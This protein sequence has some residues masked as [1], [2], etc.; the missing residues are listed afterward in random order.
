M[1]VV[2]LTSARLASGCGL[3]LEL[4]HLSLIL[5]RSVVSDDLLVGKC[6][7]TKNESMPTDRFK[8]CVRSVSE[9]FLFLL[10]GV[11]FLV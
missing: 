7:N 10:W 4:L 8:V 6:K 3:E 2:R 9:L 11:V 5:L 1:W